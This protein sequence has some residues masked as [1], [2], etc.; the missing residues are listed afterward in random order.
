MVRTIFLPKAVKLILGV[1][2]DGGHEAYAVG[3]CVRDSLRGAEPKDWD[4]CSPAPPETAAALILAASSPETVKILPIGLK[5]GGVTV[6]MDGEAYEITTFRSDGP[7]SDHRRPDYVEW[8]DSLES[9]LSRRDF[10]VNTMAYNERRG[11]VDP[12]GGLNDLKDGLIRAVGSPSERFREDAL[13]ILRAMRF[14]AVLGFSIEAATEAA[15]GGRKAL[16]AEISAERIGAELRGLLSAPSPSRVLDRHLDVVTV[17][18]PEFAAYVRDPAAKALALACLESCPSDLVSRLAALFVFLGAEAAGRALRR[19]RFP[20]HD[21][22][23]VETLARDA[24]EPLAV[25]MG[26]AADAAHVK[27]LLSRMGPERLRSALALKK[28]MATALGEDATPVEAASALLDAILEAGQCYSLASLAV[29][30]NDLMSLGIPAGPE[31]GATLRMLLE[32]VMDGDLPNER[33]ALL[34]WA[35]GNRATT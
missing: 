13:R 26:G 27:R 23:R 33:G 34:G 35:M 17:P 18:I 29:D 24:S 15:M 1:L 6:L 2:T 16:L 21:A 20:T 22:G 4:I 3:G 10:T 19:L 31:I 32:R 12:F 30:G 7:Y 8:T 25:R 5:H 28:A 9:D 11:L 14:A